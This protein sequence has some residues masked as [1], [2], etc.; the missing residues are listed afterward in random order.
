[1]SATWTSVSGQEAVFKQMQIIANNL[2]NVSTAGFK[3]ERVIFEKALTDARAPEASLRSEIQEPNPFRSSEYAGLAGSF[4]DFTQGAIENTG[5][6]LNAAI[7]GKGFFVVSNAAGEERFTRA[8]EFS[9]DA[10]GRLVTAQGLVVQGDGGELNLSGGSAC[11]QADGSVLVGQV[12]VGRL[13]VVNADPQAFEREAA[14]LFKLK[15]GESLEEIESVSLVSGAV[16]QSNVN[17]TRELTDMI[18]AART[19]ESIQKARESESRMSRARQ[20]AFGK[21]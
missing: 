1:M 21:A 20:E 3:S 11:I 5:N 9:L 6:P 13:R 19:F 14:Q 10:S 7:Q 2:A 4:T 16:E 8:G 12:V 15:E 17:A 18:M